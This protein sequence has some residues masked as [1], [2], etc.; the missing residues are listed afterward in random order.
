[1]KLVTFAVICLS[2]IAVA[3]CSRHDRSCAVKVACIIT[4]NWL[5]FAMPWI[6]APAS[7]AFLVGAPARQEDGWA[8]FDLLSMMAVINVCWRVW[9][10]PVIWS[11]YLVML[12]M[13]AVAW[14][15]GLEYLDYA[16]VLD[17]G[18]AVQLAVIFMVGGPG[19]ADRLLAGWSRIRSVGLLARK[20][21]EA[22]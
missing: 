1:M 12:S 15:N 5:L 16:A 17:A 20:G 22:S 11:I 9:W 4:L 6:Y 18:V 8:L 2:S 7:Y 13:H 19:C 14:A 10:A 3:A 21:R